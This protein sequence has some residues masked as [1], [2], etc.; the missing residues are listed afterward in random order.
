MKSHS[1]KIL[2]LVI[3][4]NVAAVAGYYFLFQNI[5]NMT[6]EATGLI[7]TIDFGQ[8]K[9][10]HLSSLRSVVKDTEKGRQQLEALLL[11]KDAEV[12]FIE[13]IEDLAKNSGLTSKTNA[14]SSVSAE[15]AVKKLQIQEEVSGSWNNV[16][17]FLNQVENLPYNIR[18]ANVSFK[19]S[20][21]S[22]SGSTW[23]AV[24]DISVSESEK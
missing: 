10:S 11:S 6:K 2:I 7:S 16:M 15:G 22:K 9:N 17:Y 24:F 18:L 19:K 8:K 4:C 23:T 12:A 3:I 13:R 5:K 21:D 1:I 20:T 14:V